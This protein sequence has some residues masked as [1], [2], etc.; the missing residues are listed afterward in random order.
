[1]NLNQKQTKYVGIALVALGVFAVLRL[2]WLLPVIAL[3]G[4]GVFMYN[5][6]RA[7]GRTSEAVQWGL[8]GIGLAL[9]TLL[10]IPFF[11]GLL[12]LGG[13]SLLLKG[14]EYVADGK[15]QALIAQFRNRRS[16]GSSY[17]SSAPTTSSTPS[18]ITIVDGDQ[19]N[20]GDTVRLK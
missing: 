2:W 12:L 20:T 1:M 16:G 6:R 19:P 8:W 15:A 17:T 18:K 5:Q 7:L 13:A 3:A 14:R 11:A 9:L 10:P 4:V